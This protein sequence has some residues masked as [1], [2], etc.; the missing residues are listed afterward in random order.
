MKVKLLAGG[1]NGDPKEHYLTSFIIND[2]LAVDAGSLPLVLSRSQQLLIRD[3]IITHSHLDH[4]AGLPLMLDNIFADMEISV[5]AYSTKETIAALH[6][7]IFNNVIWPDFSSFCNRLGARL[8]FEERQA[9][10]PFRLG[11]LEILL[12]PVNHTVPTCGVIVDDGQ[13][14]VAISSDTTDTEEIWRIAGQ[15]PR[16]KALFM[17]C[18]Y[19]NRLE[20]L[21]YLYGH[22]C[23]SLLLKQVQ[24]VGKDVPCYAYHIKAA[25]LRE[26]M[27]ELEGLAGV[28][29]AE[30]CVEY[31]V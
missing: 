18:S 24:K 21:A 5:S 11:E 13:S 16:L 15:N 14:A 1:S 31:E 4:L 8:I 19:P 29:A 3:V 2:S 9:L 30:P 6:D 23:P 25:Y 28:V 22:L 20:R 17:E 12:V 26:I 27:T 7:H 10:T